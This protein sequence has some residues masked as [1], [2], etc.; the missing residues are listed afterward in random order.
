MSLINV[1]RQG[2]MKP[3]RIL[4]Y[5]SHKIGKSTFASGAP[6]PIFIQTEDG[7]DNLSVDAFPLATSYQE[8]IEAMGTLFN[9]THDYQT[10]VIDSMDWLEKLVWQ[11]VCDDSG[12]HKK[13]EDFGYGKGY[14]AALDVWREF[15]DGLNA[16]RTQKNM[17][18]I[19]ICHTEIRRFDSPE[20][21][22]YDRY[23]P[24]LNAK[25]TALVSEW[26]DALGFANYRV[27]TKEVTKKF[28]EEKAHRGVSTGERI[29]NLE[30]KA[31]F[32]AGNRYGLPASVPFTWDAFNAALITATTKK[33]EGKK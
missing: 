29:L 32:L 31:S 21:D 30:E 22:A 14:V 11:K 3:P 4:V 23:Q 7:L 15:L 26:V 12:K 5:G 27:V 25:A 18:I 6:K 13:I 10:V 17:S 16:L 8:V 28:S 24:K 19:C 1:S 2:V 20:T 33:E 9:E